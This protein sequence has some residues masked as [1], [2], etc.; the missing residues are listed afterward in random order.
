MKIRKEQMDAL[1]AKKAKRFEDRL[2]AHI[3]DEYP[4]V[5]FDMPEAQV[6][7]RVRA[8]LERAR[9]YDMQTEEDLAA[10]TELDFELGECF[11]EQQQW[12]AEVVNDREID[13]HQKIVAL[14]E[15]YYEFDDG[16]DEDFDALPEKEG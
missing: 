12:A 16:D 15:I 9:R 2:V 5:V 8:C 7:D 4:D 14:E 13:G 1:G 10:F 6:R 11:D 3:Q